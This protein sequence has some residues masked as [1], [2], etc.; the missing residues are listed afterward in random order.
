MSNQRKQVLQ[1]YYI[2]RGELGTVGFVRQDFREKKVMQE[3]DCVLLFPY[4]Y[5]VRAD[6]SM[7]CAGKSSMGANN[8]GLSQATE[9]DCQIDLEQLLGPLDPGMQGVGIIEIVN[10]FSTKPDTDAS[11]EAPKSYIWFDPGNYV[12]ILHD[13]YSVNEDHILIHLGA[14]EGQAIRKL[15]AAFERITGEPVGK[16]HYIPLMSLPDDADV[17]MQPMSFVHN[18]EESITIEEYGAFNTLLGDIEIDL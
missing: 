9:R 15:V 3:G 18:K 16:I 5:R 6:G 4:W 1:D 10:N 12:H 11:V 2:H 13:F 8:T 17:L 7:E 14:Y